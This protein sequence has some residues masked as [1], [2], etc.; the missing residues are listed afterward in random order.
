MELIKVLDHGYVKICRIDGVDVDI[1]NC[2]RASFV[3]EV[4]V[5]TPGFI[6]RLANEGHSSPFRSVGI[7]VEVKMPLCVRQQYYKHV[8]GVSNVEDGTNWNEQSGRNKR[9][10][11]F[12]CPVPREPKGKWGQGQVLEEYKDEFKDDLNIAYASALSLYNKWVERGV[13][14]ENIRQ[15][16]PY[17]LYTTVRSR[18]SLQAAFYFWESRQ[19]SH[20][21]LEIQEYAK[22]IDIICSKHFPISWD[23]LKLANKKDKP[24]VWL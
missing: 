10:Y 11:E 19:D 18:M 2:A 21:Q 7:W 14:V 6:E 16:I 23:A 5:V 20:A 3:K 24:N 1:E 22:A 4:V 17:G 8:I 12:Y 15:V 9:V 13:A